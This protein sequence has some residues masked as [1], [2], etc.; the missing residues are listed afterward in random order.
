MMNL[1]RNLFGGAN[2]RSINGINQNHCT[3]FVQIL[4]ITMLEHWF[5]PVISKNIAVSEHTFG[6]KVFFFNKKSIIDCKI[7]IVGIASEEANIIRKE[8]YKCA[9]CVPKDYVTDLGNLRNLDPDFLIGGLKEI[10]SSNIIPIVIG[11][12]E[13]FIQSQFKAYHEREKLPTA[14]IVDAQLRYGLGDKSTGYLNAILETKERQKGLFHLSSLASQSHLVDSDVWNTLEFQDYDLIR[15]GVLRAKMEQAEPL[16]READ[17]MAF[18]INAIRKSDASGQKD[19]ISSGLFIEEACQLTRYAGMS[20]RLTSIGF[21]GYEKKYD[22]SGQTAKSIAQ[23]IWYFIEGV[24]NRKQDY[25]VSLEGMTEYLVEIN[26][27]AEPLTFWKSNKTQRWWI[28]LP[29]AKKKQNH[30]LS[31]SYADYKE[32]CDGE[33]PERIWN[34]FRKY[35]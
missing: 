34:G 23:M 14:A 25:P 22:P 35:S 9:K 30:L 1:V 20:D 33:L 5:K 28:Q 17:G 15:L 31:C 29:D 2:I 32:A 13:T 18:H 3:I 16:I 8:L 19:A 11:G 26:G 21:Y 4:K 24:A 12:G 27:F 7:A 6:E 10:I